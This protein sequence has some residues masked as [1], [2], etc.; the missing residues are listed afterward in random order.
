MVAVFRA[1]S[2]D[3]EGKKL[4]KKFKILKFVLERDFGCLIPWLIACPGDHL[5]FLLGTFP[6]LQGDTMLVPAND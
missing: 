1:G 5:L 6:Q 3:T 2:F 4:Q